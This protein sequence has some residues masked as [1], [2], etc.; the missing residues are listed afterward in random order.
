MTANAFISRS[1]NPPLSPIGKGQ[2][3][4]YLEVN[5][6]SPPFELIFK[7]LENDIQPTFDGRGLSSGENRKAQSKNLQKLADLALDTFLSYNYSSSI[8]IPVDTF[9]FTFS[10]PDL[11]PVPTF[12][13]EGDLIT[14][15]GNG[16]PVSTG[17]IDQVEVEI[18]D[19]G[20]ERASISGR[21][22][23]SQLED[24]DAVS[25]NSGKNFGGNT[26]IENGVRR[27]CED[28]RIT[29]F[30]FTRAPTGQF[31]WAT[32]AG[33]SKLTALQRLLEPANCV[34]WMLPSGALK[35]GQPNMSANSSGDL[36]CLQNSRESN[37]ISI[38]ATRAC[39][40]IPN[41]IAVIWPIQEDVTKEATL[42]KQVYL[43]AAYGPERLRKLGHTLPKSVVIA[44]P[45]G[46]AP[47]DYDAVNKL[48]FAN[49][50][51]LD[52]YAKREIARANVDELIVQIVVN[53]HYNESGMPYLPDTVYNIRFDRGNIDQDMYLYQ[54]DYRMSEDTGQLTNLYF[55]NLGAIVAGIKTKVTDA[56]GTEL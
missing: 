16:V 55:C 6:R 19:S 2:L 4:R 5:G 11:D 30:D 26:T 27:L 53:G 46:N 18:D 44:V 45:D 8:L 34:A 25:L 40:R 43:N 9:S 32:E 28:T 50:D 38:K 31:L 7:P 41:V 23:L 21:D 52:Q 37:V 17:I 15:A 36:F 35:I 20:G 48:Q 14:L 54:T 1:E 56:E 51:R 39:S 29:Q 33:E 13:R 10:R 49:G 47:T 24:Q 12:L 3:A 22:L 42:P